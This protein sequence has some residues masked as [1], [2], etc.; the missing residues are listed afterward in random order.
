MT[1]NCGRLST[2]RPPRLGERHLHAE[3][4]RLHQFN[5]LK[6]GFSRQQRPEGT[7][8]LPLEVGC[9]VRHGLGEGRAGLQ[10][11]VAHPIPL[12]TLTGEEPDSVAGRV[13]RAALDDDVD[14]GSGCAKTRNACAGGTPCCR[15]PRRQD[16][17]HLD[18]RGAWGDL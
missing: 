16:G 10:E 7:S 3:D 6:G 2:K 1:N 9:Q 4:G 18:V 8:R 5:S 12:G 15:R 11:V 13:G 17:R 14:V